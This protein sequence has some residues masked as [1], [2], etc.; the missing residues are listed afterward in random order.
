MRRVVGFAPLLL[1]TILAGCGIGGDG[2]GGGSSGTSPSITSFTATPSSI[3]AAVQPVTLSWTISGT[4]TSLSISPGIGTVSGS[5]TTVYPTATTTYTLTATNSYGNDVATTTVTVAST[6][7]PPPPPDG[8]DGLPPSGTFGVSLSQSGPFQSDVDGIIT[9]ADDERIIQVEP[10]STFYAQVAYTDPGGI[11]GVSVRLV[12][13]EPAGLAADLVVGQEVGGF[14]LVGEPSG[15]LLDGTRTTVNCLYEIRVGD[16]PNIDQLEGSGNEFA[17]VFR[18][19]VTDV[20]GNGA[21][22]ISNRGYVIVEGGSS[23]VFR[24]RT[25]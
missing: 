3:T 7:P 15:C 5:S 21:S 23:V 18:T 16:I 24:H 12:N 17:Y 25:E 20:A 6:P 9:S 22:S 2:G 19:I 1:L 11:A 10:N 4:V 14:T 13:T 8:E